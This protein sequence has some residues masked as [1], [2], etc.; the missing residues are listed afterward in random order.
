MHRAEMLFEQAL[1]AYKEGLLVRALSYW[2]EA[3]TIYGSLDLEKVAKCDFQIGIVFRLLGRADQ[4]ITHYELAKVAFLQLGLDELVADCD[5]NL[6]NAFCDFNQPEQAL[7][8]FERAKSEFLRLALDKGVATC[9]L[10][11]GSTLKDFFGKSKEAINHYQKAKK[12]FIRLRFDKEVAD[13]DHNMGISLQS[14]GYLQKAIECFSL[15]KNVFRK[16]GLDQRVAACEIGIG[17]SL[18]KLG[19]PQKALEHFEQAKTI[20]LQKGLTKELIDCEINIG[21]ALLGLGQLQKAMECY[22]RGKAFYLKHN[23]QKD[24]ADCEFSIGGV[25]L[26]TGHL[27]R[28]ITHYERARV[29]FLYQ[30]FYKMAADCDFNIGT[31]LISLKQ[32]HQAIKHLERAKDYY[33]RFGL[34]WNATECHVNIGVAISHIA[35]QKDVENVQ[36]LYEQALNDLDIAILNIENLRAEITMTSYR[37]T[38]FDQYISAYIAAINCCLQLGHVADALHYLERSRSKVLAEMVRANLVPDQNE[39]GEELYSEFLNLRTRLHQMGLLPTV[40]NDFN[41]K[42]ESDDSGSTR[43]QAQQN[44]D[45]LVQRIAREFPN[46]AFSRRLIATEV[47]YLEDVD[48]YIDLLPDNRSCLLEFL[49]WADNGRLRAFLVTKQKQIELLVFPKESL[50]Q[51]NDIWQRWQKM[52]IGELSQA[53]KESLVWEVCHQLHELIFNA[54]IEVVRESDD[55]DLS[56]NSTHHRLLDYLNTILE[57]S[58]DKQLR[59]IYLIPHAELFFM[60]LHAACYSE[61][62]SR[63]HYLLEDY[64]VI[65]APSAYLLKVSKEREYPE[66]RQSRALVVG[67]PL[68]LPK[69]MRSLPSAKEEIEEAAMH[70]EEAGWKVDRLIEN[71]ATKSNY[72]DGDRCEVSGIN[73]GDY[74]H[75]H[76]ALH[77]YFGTNGQQAGLCFGQ[78]SED[79]VCYTNDIIGAP[80]QKTR[81]VIA[82]ACF[83]STTDF[84][85]QYLNE[86]L[87][88]GAAF[89]QAGVGTFI[90]SLYELSDAGSK[91]IMSELYR[92]HLKDGLSWAEALRSA[93]LA[94]LRKN[95][96]S[97]FANRHAGPTSTGE[98][99]GI[100]PPPKSLQDITDKKDLTHPYHWAALTISGKE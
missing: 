24:V 35:V 38:F 78:S 30:G 43:R 65:Y 91:Q 8:Y 27:H 4:A 39:I 41:T 29:A 56:S 82:A 17:V 100:E 21:N 42:P 15:A 26:K 53:E 47:R 58:T 74:S 80:L 75:Q 28:A 11:I 12:I 14:L 83:T 2:K 61:N 13:C 3:K 10:N 89:L 5:N 51:L 90:G 70:L 33:L 84:S 69:G 98:M 23:L 57:Q 54:E 92:L 59:R 93:H 66:P 34:E 68:P 64:V 79:F 76:L 49:T 16:L 97:D 50:K 6:G 60:P 19:Q 48:E 55:E 46:S 62:G 37:I 18:R 67:N 7:E 31:G 52:Y 81:S 87:G 40:K 94:L 25:L 86:Y 20:H 71:A 22:E 96:F 1:I 77:G 45:S 85:E 44:F 95:D 73:S 9:E 99:L 36:D 32:L 72:L 88:I 63:E